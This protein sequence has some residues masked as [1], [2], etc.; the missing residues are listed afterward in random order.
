ML[1]VRLPPLIDRG[2]ALYLPIPR[3]T[4]TRKHFCDDTQQLKNR[5]LY[6]CCL[7]CHGG[8]WNQRPIILISPHIFRNTPYLG[9]TDC[10]ATRESTNRRQTNNKVT[11]SSHG[12]WGIFGADGTEKFRHGHGA[13]SDVGTMLELQQNALCCCVPPDQSQ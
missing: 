7:C 10:T 1:H 13:I 12:P 4:K 6:Y 5:P 2:S 9:Q 3:K 11:T 8:R